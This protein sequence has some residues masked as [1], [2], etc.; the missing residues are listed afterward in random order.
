[1]PLD[2]LPGVARLTVRSV[3]VVLSAAVAPPWSLPPMP[4]NC[5]A[6]TVGV[7]V[8]P[9]MERMRCRVAAWVVSTSAGQTKS[10]WISSECEEAQVMRVEGSVAPFTRAMLGLVSVARMPPELAMAR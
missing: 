3:G 10:H 8:A 6:V 9:P 5:F 4:V 1:M 7:L 2:R